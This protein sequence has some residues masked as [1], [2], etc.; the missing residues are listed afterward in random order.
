[1]ESQLRKIWDWNWGVNHPTY[2]LHALTNIWRFFTQK[3]AVSVKSFWGAIT[4]GSG[5]LPVSWYIELLASSWILIISISPKKENIQQSKDRELLLKED[6]AETDH[7]YPCLGLANFLLLVSI[8]NIF[9]VYQARKY[10]LLFAFTNDHKWYSLPQGGR[11]CAGAR[12]APAE[13]FGLG[14]KF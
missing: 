10:R 9:L 13:K 14:R 5:V 12:V 7:F 11:S 4:L 8:P 6:M 3:R 1:M 2:S